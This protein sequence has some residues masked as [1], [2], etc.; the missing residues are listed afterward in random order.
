MGHYQKELEMGHLLSIRVVSLVALVIAGGCLQASSPGAAQLESG[1]PTMVFAGTM[2]TELA[3]HGDGNVY[4][5]EVHFENG[6]YRMWYGGQGTDRHDRIF[7]AESS[8]G[9]AWQKK[10]VVLDIDAADHVN[11]PTVVKVGD[12]YFMYYTRAMKWV[13]DAIHVAT[14]SD[15]VNWQPRGVAVA[16]GEKGQWDSLLVGRPSVLHEDGVFKMWYDGRKEDRRSVGYATSAD[17]IVWQEHPANPVFDP[18]DGPGG[19]HVAKVEGVYVMLYEFFDGVRL[20]T[21]P[22]G[23]EWHSHG[24]WL[25][26]SGQP[27]DQHG[28]VTPF[29]LLRGTRPWAV[30]FG[31]AARLS[32]DNNAIGII[33][34]T[35]D[36][37]DRFLAPGRD[38]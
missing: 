36:E 6:L 10:G 29:L 21:S 16:P 15:G 11:D 14:S 19:I 23:L 3:P 7:Y 24:L 22:D 17:G 26:I 32:W 20:A 28:H 34:L 8:D 5:P 13:S 35:G 9:L 33:R 31:A 12:V 38:R 18:V 37:L 4:A 25:K 30:Y 2:E 1:V 27:F